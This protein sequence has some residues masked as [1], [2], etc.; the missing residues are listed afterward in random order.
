MIPII[1]K[2]APYSHFLCL[3]YK[4]QVRNPIFNQSEEN[5]EECKIFIACMGVIKLLFSLW[6]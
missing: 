6:C 2:V 3:L 4:S 1:G 5:I